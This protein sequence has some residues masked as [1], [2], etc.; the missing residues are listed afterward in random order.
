LLSSDIAVRIAVKISPRP[1]PAIVNMDGELVPTSRARVSIFDRGFLAGD[2][3][4]EVVR[5][6]G[7]APFALPEHLGRLARSAARIGLD[8]PWGPGRLE[9]EITRTIEASRGGDE[10]DPGAAP[11]NRGERSVRLVV[12]RGAAEEARAW[13]VDPGPRVMIA[14]APLRGPPASAY[15]EGVACLLVPAR[16]PRADAQAKTGGHLAEALAAREALAAG[17]HE[18]LFVD[19][20]GRVTEG[21]SSN[22]FRVKA[23]RLETPPPSAGILAGVT[24]GLVLALAREAGLA[25][26]ERE[27]SRAEFEEADE[28]F[29]TS[30]TREVLPVTLLGGRRVGAGSPGPVT[31][32]L[33]HLFREAAAKRAGPG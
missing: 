5:T 32:R 24:R 3:V 9:R 16:V 17:A 25:A 1:M 20:A 12:T 19:G 28:V 21:S 11:W 14:A 27:L 31:A 8:L 2:L 6:Y 4:Y 26:A 13:G 10:P 7:L 29:L 33:H 15:R 30:T 23:G 18:A 22:V